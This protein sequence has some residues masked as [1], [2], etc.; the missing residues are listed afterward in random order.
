MYQALTALSARWLSGSGSAE[1]GQKSAQMTRAQAQRST[2]GNCGRS[3]Q[4]IVVAPSNQ[5]NCPPQTD[6]RQKQNSQKCQQGRIGESLGNDWIN[7]NGND[8]AQQRRA[9]IAFNVPRADK[10]HRSETV[11][12]RTNRMSCA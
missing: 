11:H 5:Q 2:E 7:G 3:S 1:D 6:H 8:M 12:D 4:P 10:R 9:R